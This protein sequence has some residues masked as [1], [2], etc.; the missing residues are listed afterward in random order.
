[1]LVSDDKLFHIDIVKSIDGYVLQPSDWS[2]VN[3]PTSVVQARAL[4]SVYASLRELS[5]YHVCLA[6]CRHSSTSEELHSLGNVSTF[7]STTGLKCTDIIHICYGGTSRK[8]AAR[9]TP[10]AEMGFLTSWRPKLDYKATTWFNSNFANATNVW[11]VTKHTFLDGTAEPVTKTRWGSFAWEIGILM[12][13]LASMR[14]F[15]TFLYLGNPNDVSLIS[16]VK[17]VGQKCF[18]YTDDQESAEQALLLYNSWE[19]TK[20]WQKYF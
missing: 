3:I 8:H 7:L 2:I 1:M 18:I 12:M 16:F 20:K 9:L 19:G 5:K 15:S 17:T 10:I 14:E 6:T 13:G 4:A 11:D